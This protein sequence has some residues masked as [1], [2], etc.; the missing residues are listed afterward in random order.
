M[1][2]LVHA[3]GC[4]AEQ[5]EQLFFSGMV[6]HCSIDTVIPYILDMGV[7][8]PATSSGQCLEFVAFCLPKKVRQTK[9]NDD[10]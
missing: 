10:L 1:L 5:L 8:G 9:D 3:E 2:T 4:E 7:P 6:E